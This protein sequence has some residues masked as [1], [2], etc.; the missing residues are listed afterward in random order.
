[1]RRQLHI[2]RSLDP[3]REC[4]SSGKV[5]NKTIRV[6]DEIAAVRATEWRFIQRF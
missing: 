2:P 4:Q 1:M 3:K 6:A 5:G